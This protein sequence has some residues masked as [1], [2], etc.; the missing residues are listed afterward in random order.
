MRSIFLMDSEH[1]C[2]GMVKDMCLEELNAPPFFLQRK[3]RV[4]IVKTRKLWSVR[5][6]RRRAYLA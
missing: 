4:K 5:G 3:G 6:R 1:L 2:G